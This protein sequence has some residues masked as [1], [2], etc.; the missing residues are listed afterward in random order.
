[1]ESESECKSSV[2][3]IYFDAIVL[4]RLDDKA[5]SLARSRSWMVNFMLR[6]ALG[7]QT[8]GEGA[9]EKLQRSDNG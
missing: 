9:Y 3:S 2:V 5:R 4:A 1:M 6:P 8:E 7:I